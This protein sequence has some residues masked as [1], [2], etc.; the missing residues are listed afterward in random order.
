MNTEARACR[1]LALAAAAAVMTVAVAA[2]G[3]SGGVGGSPAAAQA[4]AGQSVTLRSEERRVGKE[5]SS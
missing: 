2:C 5:C 4:T 1:R 3:N